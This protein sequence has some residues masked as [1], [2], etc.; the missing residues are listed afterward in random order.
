MK[1]GVVFLELLNFLSV[2]EKSIVVVIIVANSDGVWVWDN[3][4]GFSEL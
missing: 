2:L 1:L 3:S 4:I